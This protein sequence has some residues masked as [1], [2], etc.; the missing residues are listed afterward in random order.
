VLCLVLYGFE[1]WSFALEEE[2]W[3][4]VFENGMVRSL[5]GLK[6]K[7]TAGCCRKI[8]KKE[9]RDIHPSPHIFM[10]IKSRGMRWTGLGADL[11]DNRFAHKGFDGLMDNDCLKGPGVHGKKMV[12]RIV[13]NSIG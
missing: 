13:R 12:K 3:L 7:L 2:Y 8:H 5:F 10:V 9:L 4:R 11:G 6:K 1:I